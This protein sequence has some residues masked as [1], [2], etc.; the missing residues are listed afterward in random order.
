MQ[1]ENTMRN[2]LLASTAVMTAVLFQFGV[3]APALAQ[4][5]AAL[6]GKVS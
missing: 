5:A 1:K 6:T 4:S 2:A 3:A